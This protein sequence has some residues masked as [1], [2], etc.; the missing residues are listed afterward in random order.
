M[1]QRLMTED[2]K[3]AITMRAEELRK[4][5]RADEARALERTKPLPAYLARMLKERVGASFLTQSDWNLA[6]AEAEYGQG[7]LDR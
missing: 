3:V 7:W 6:E 1:M 4:Q 5:G 2:E